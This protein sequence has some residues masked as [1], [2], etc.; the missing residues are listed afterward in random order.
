MAQHNQVVR[1]AVVGS[2]K[3]G[4][5]SLIKRV[6]S[7]RFDN[8]D[9]LN[10]DFMGVPS[11]GR[12]LVSMTL[13]TITGIASTKLPPSILLELQDQLF[14]A[15]P[16]LREPFWFT[17]A[18][19]AE[20][21]VVEKEPSLEPPTTSAD[22]GAQLH[23]EHWSRHQDSHQSKALA[24]AIA[25][26]GGM[27]QPDLHPLMAH[28][29]QTLAKESANTLA[30]SNSEGSAS[31]LTSPHGTH[32][33]M[34]AFDMRSRESYEA[35]KAMAL[36]L[37]E[38]VQAERG[39]QKAFPVSIVVVGNKADLVTAHANSETCVS[40]LDVC[41]LLAAGVATNSIVAQLRRQH[42][43]RPL[44]KLVDA[45][46]QHR[47]L[48]DDAQAKA[49]GGSSKARLKEGPGSNTVFGSEVGEANLGGVPLSVIPALTKLRAELDPMRVGSAACSALEAITAIRTAI[50]HPMA[51]NADV[52]AAELQEALQACPALTIKYVEVSCKTNANM[53]TL[54]RIMLRAVASSVLV[55]SAASS[56]KRRSDNRSADSGCVCS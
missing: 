41:E 14:S 52:P 16:L 34:I 21:V 18:A 33:W 50:A 38:R 20:P 28:Q 23:T 13:P 30:L 48:L 8:L 31:L 39:G 44:L 36:N 46:V 10:K 26:Q 17:V 51:S 56:A 55:P 5:S 4:K 19:P 37:L 42:A 7:H 11:D 6:V 43:D 29:F 25:A 49:M 27:H 40:E 47:K 54:E 3:C 15:S 1:I 35:A 9:T 32:G 2:P 24:T 45:I 22:A 53:H 12:H